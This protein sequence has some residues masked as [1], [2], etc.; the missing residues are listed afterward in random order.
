[1]KIYKNL[2]F[3]SLKD[4]FQNLNVFKGDSKF[5]DR[6]MNI[7]DK[8]KKNF[9][10]SQKQL[11]KEKYFLICKEYVYHHDQNNNYLIFHENIIDKIFEL[12]EGMKEKLI[13]LFYSFIKNQNKKSNFTD[14]FFINNDYSKNEKMKYT[15]F[16][17]LL[18]EYIH[19]ILFCS[20]TAL[21]A[22]YS[23]NNEIFEQIMDTINN[24]INQEKVEIFQQMIVKNFEENKIDD[25]NCMKFKS[26]SQTLIKKEKT[27][28]NV[29]IFK[30]EMEKIFE[31]NEYLHN[32]CELI[33]KYFKFFEI[34][35][36]SCI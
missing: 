12:C 8:A 9:E 36:Q 19:K 24:K 10:N 32:I 18:C 6:I 34:K 35:N 22:F 31:D 2:D 3:N 15:R 7:S 20:F 11:L 17:I 4:M 21:G 29:D 26:V 30:D 5:M 13:L 33:D 16:K 27:L 28:S 25:L 14:L 1:M 23:K